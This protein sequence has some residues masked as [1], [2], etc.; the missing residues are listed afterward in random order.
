M[1]HV[2]IMA[3]IAEIGLHF[4]ADFVRVENAF[5]LIVKESKKTRG[6]FRV[7]EHVL[8]VFL[9]QNGRFSAQFVDDRPARI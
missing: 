1:D 5:G 9:R 3:F 4:Q 6:E 8:D 7:A 2:Q